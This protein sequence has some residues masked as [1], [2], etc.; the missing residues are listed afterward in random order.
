MTVLQLEIIVLCV[1]RVLKCL[2]SICLPQVDV[3]GY[4]RLPI[5]TSKV[6][7][8]CHLHPSGFH[9]VTATR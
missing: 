7:I 1:Y 6:A 3:A 5:V 8:G 4:Y 2:A 9:I